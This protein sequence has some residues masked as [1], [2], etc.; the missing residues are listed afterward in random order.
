MKK[1][2]IQFIILI[3]V[4][5]GVYSQP[6]PSIYQIGTGT[7]RLAKVA[8]NTPASNS[9][10]R[11][12]I[13]NNL[14]WLGT[15]NGL[16]KSADYGTTWTN[17]YKSSV[18]GTESISAIG[19]YNGTVWAAT[20]HSYDLGS[21]S[22]DGQGT[23]LK[24]SSDQGQT[25]TSISQPVD[26][27]GDSSIVYGINKL[28]ALP[29]TTTVSNF[30][31]SIG[32]TKNT[33]WIAC[34][35]AGLRKSTDNGKTWQRVVLPPD[36]L[37]SIKPTDTLHFSLQPVAGKFGSEAYLNHEAFSILAVDDNTIY[38]GTAGGI[39]KSTDGGVSWVKFNHSNQNSPISGNFIWTMA[40]NEY[41]NSIWA[42]T[43]KAE[44]Q[45]EFYGLSA[46]KDGGKSWSTYLTGERVHDFGF[47]YFG[48]SGSYTGADVIAATES[49]LFRTS[50]SGT[51]WI[52]APL[53]KDDYTNVTI[54]TT[55]FSS[56]KTNRRTDNSTDIWMGS[57][58]GLSRLNESAAGFWS[59]SWKVFLA[60]TSLA[61]TNDTYAFPNPF[62]PNRE[63]IKIKYFTN[64]SGNVTIRIMDF[65]MNLVRTVIQNASRSANSQQVE[66]WDGKDQN[67]RL[68]PNGVYF[69]RIDLAS[70]TPLYG[71]IMVL[72]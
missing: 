7:S 6:L 62:S 29:V 22:Y 23:G 21:G 53:I 2:L 37:N 3:L 45:N 19:A 64:E 50:N 57:D 39:N 5:A 42:A 15:G 4:S 20:W 55:S 65:G 43:W 1:I 13:S 66:V 16:S 38:V 24:Y 10:D 72:M 35:A 34:K 46:S 33:V 17:Y 58:N 18:F 9:I 69:Y 14:I 32:F 59:G 36:Y 61:S 54:N 27:P 67:G 56:V 63:V 40:L 48:T 11:I 68:V 51:T 52:T 31:Y 26:D 8:D 12:Y 41:D 70:G 49:G 60:S 44:S 25:W 28:R 30:V 47:K 71:K